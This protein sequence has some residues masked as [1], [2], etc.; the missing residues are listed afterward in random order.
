MDF[1]RRF[2]DQTI[3]DCLLD[4]HS[5]PI[6]VIVST[7]V[8]VERDMS[9]FPSLQEANTLLR[10]LHQNIETFGFRAAI[11]QIYS[12]LFCSGESTTLPQVPSNLWA[13]SFVMFMKFLSPH[14]CHPCPLVL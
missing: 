1:P 6:T 11:I 2:L 13:A 5:N 8:V 10:S 14:M 12:Q 4:P 9:H 7:K 3:V